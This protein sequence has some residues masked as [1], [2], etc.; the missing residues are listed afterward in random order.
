M[1]TSASSYLDELK[2]QTDKFNTKNNSSRENS[3]N[4]FNKMTDYGSP[5]QDRSPV[6]EYNLSPNTSAR[7]SNPNEHMTAQGALLEGGIP[8]SPTT[9]KNEVGLN[10]RDLMTAQSGDIATSA[11][12]EM[13]RKRQEQMA[14]MLSQFGNTN[15]LNGLGQSSGDDDQ[16]SNARL[17]QQIAKQR[18]LGDDAA[19][20]AI[21][22]GLAESELKNINHGDRDS[23]GIFQ[24][25]PSQ[26]WGTP[27][28][29]TD[30]NYAINKFF[31]SL[32]KIN[33]QGMTPWAAAQA[34][35]RSAYSDG[36][37]YQARYAAAQSL[38]KNASNPQYSNMSSGKASVN[39]PGLNSWINANN[40]KYLDYDGAYGAQCVDLY[41]FYTTGFAGGRPNPVGY[42]PEIFT[43]Y[44]SNAYARFANNSPARAGDV[45]IWNVGQYT[46]SGHVAIVVGDNG[47]GTL[48]VLQSNATSLGSAGNSI[49]SNISKSALMGYLRPRK[50]M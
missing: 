42:A 21:M 10:E 38:L 17:I 29:V 2:R 24:Q 5:I 33:Y 8:A 16:L 47:D 50:L 22:T 7:Y 37:N 44:D 23:L 4:S 9:R 34:V 28:Q 13:L 15:D 26:G 40:N 25:R 12:T 43:N 35:Q 48:R 39:D 1:V 6:G 49:I 30:P 19:L 14:K 32:Q 41:A 3:G 31:D 27:Q 45:A 36:S 18:G 11:S 46:P 20:I